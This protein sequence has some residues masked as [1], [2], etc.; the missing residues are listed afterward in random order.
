[1]RRSTRVAG[2][3]TQPVEPIF[4]E[5]QLM[6]E[7][8]P[9]EDDSDGE[10]EEQK[11]R[12]AS[13]K[14]RG[15]KRKKPANKA[16]NPTPAKKLRGTRGCLK[17]I[18]EMP[19]DILVEIF[20]HLDPL[21]LIHLSW[22]T[23]AFRALLL[24]KNADSNAIWKASIA[25]V[26]RFPPCPEDLSEPKYAHLAFVNICHEIDLNTDFLVFP[27]PALQGVHRRSVN[28]SS[29][30]SEISLTPLQGF[31]WM[32]SRFTA[33]GLVIPTS[34][35]WYHLQASI[36]ALQKLLEHCDE[37]IIWLKRVEAESRAARLSAAEA[38]K[39]VVLEML[40]NLG[41]SEEI[42][43]LE[44]NEDSFAVHPIDH[45]A[46]VRASKKKITDQVLADLKPILVAYME[47]VKKAR[48]QNIRSRLLRARLA[49]LEEVYKPY[50][51][52]LPA[53]TVYPSLADIFFH[54]D[55]QDIMDLPSE[56]EVTSRNFDQIRSS[57]STIVSQVL[58]NL[59]SE[60]N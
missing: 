4:E 38:R 13:K 9:E 6:D 26:P 35:T 14:K 33:T 23:K 15:T 39:P 59:E 36:M 10:D 30:L 32:N 20:G 8:T 51:A 29:N 40:K 57:F 28:P 12:G 34:G 56:T 24:S 37:C 22:T 47:N 18:L 11:G 41:W 42:A 52:E 2:R 60:V 55:V 27:S 21:D 25:N 7:F 5:D 48:L 1:M 49:L 58:D 50:V 53:N 45:S 19:M 3:K 17:D 44:A 46:V 16:T 43:M 54:P 31:V